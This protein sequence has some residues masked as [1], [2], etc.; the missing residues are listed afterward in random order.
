MIKK[1]LN[2]ITPLYQA[3]VYN[4][5]IGGTTELNRAAACFKMANTKLEQGNEKFEF[6]QFNYQLGVVY[7]LKALK[8]YNGEN[9]WVFPLEI[10]DADFLENRRGGN[11]YGKPEEMKRMLDSADGYFNKMKTIKSQ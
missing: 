8:E 9:K 2:Q 10:L 7:F 5:L 3:G 6:P 1:R 11:D 4:L